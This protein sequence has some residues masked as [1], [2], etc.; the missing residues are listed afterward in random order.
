MFT[1]HIYVE[2]DTTIPRST[3]RKA[4][5]VL[6]YTRITGGL[7]TKEEIIEKTDTYHG[8]I[9]AALEAALGRINKSCELHLHSRDEYVINSIEKNLPAWK[10]NGYRTKKGDLV[11]NH[12]AWRRIQEKLE[13]HLIV[14]EPGPHSYLSWMLLQMAKTG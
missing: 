10:E 6:E 1:V 2:T 14:I 4:M 9:L 3:G 13:S 8:A 11:K 12:F 5:Y 7:Y